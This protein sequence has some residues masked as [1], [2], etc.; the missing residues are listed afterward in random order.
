M[1]K[2]PMPAVLKGQPWS[3]LLWEDV[4]QYTTALDRLAAV[5]QQGV[6]VDVG[7][8]IGCAALLFHLHYQAR[9]ISIEAIAETYRQLLSNCAGYPAIEPIHAAVGAEAGEAWLNRYPLAPGLGGHEASRLH[10]LLVLWRQTLGN[11]A[12][13]GLVDALLL[14]L[15]LL[16]ALIWMLCCIP[17]VSI[18]FRQR[19]Q[20]QTLSGIL[21]TH[22]PT[23][24]VDL[25]K[26][27]IEGH[28]LA[29]LLGLAP[30]DWGRINCLVMEVHAENLAAVRALLVD[31]GFEIESLQQGL[32]TV[33]A[34]PSVLVA[35]RAG[36]AS[37]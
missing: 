17:I 20:V 13:R 7:G 33:K 10:L 16:G 8:N 1:S 2:H 19:V 35:I 36:G 9:V 4:S 15:R 30:A 34:A 29:A 37:P 26:I 23:G 32:I 22:V 5:P 28:E 11:L 24:A 21:A 27:D 14:P 12:I 18:R 3:D 25:L 31:K 6:V